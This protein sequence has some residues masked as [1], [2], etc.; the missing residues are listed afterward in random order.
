M[1][2]S[3]S[4]RVAPTV[5]FDA[6]AGPESENRPGVLRNVGLEQGDPDGS[7][8][9]VGM[10]VRQ[11]TNPAPDKG[12][13]RLLVGTAIAGLRSPG[14]GANKTAPDGRFFPSP[15]ANGGPPP[16]AAMR[17]TARGFQ[18]RRNDRI[19]RARRP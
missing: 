2:D 4:L 1:R 9:R 8:F 3:N 11:G 13:V 17:V 16:A 6:E 18:R 19:E 14:K 5:D 7:G 10:E 15:R 12:F